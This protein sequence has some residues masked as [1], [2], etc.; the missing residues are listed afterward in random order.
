MSTLK[1]YSAIPFI[2]LTAALLSACGDRPKVDQV[3]A[4][5][6]E[7]RNSP[8][9]R[10]EPLPNYPEPLIAEYT[11]QR[12]RDP[13]T[14]SQLLLQTIASSSPLAPDLSRP[15]TALEQWDLNQLTFRGSMQRGGDIRGLILAPDNQLFTVRT[16]DKMGRDHGTITHIS[17]STITLREVVSDISGQWQEREQQLFISR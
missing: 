13:F 1:K 15:R 17:G 8:Q 16:G 9:G 10:I 12:Q 7:L 14:P 5:L 3:N 6:V 11:Q 2:L 4:R